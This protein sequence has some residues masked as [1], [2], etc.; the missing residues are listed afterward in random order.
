MPYY[1]YNFSGILDSY[2]GYYLFM[3][4]GILA[5]LIASIAVKSTFRRYSSVANSRGMTGADA[6]LAVLRAYG[7]TDVTV[8]RVSGNL[9][10]NYDPR[11]KVIHLSESVY[12]SRS[13]AAVGVAAHEAGHAAQ[14]AAG[15]APVKLRMA[16]IPVCNIGAQLALPLLIL[17]SVFNFFGLMV[18]GLALF[19]LS[20]FFQ[21]VTLPVEFNASRRALAV[22]REHDLL[23]GEEY[24]GAKKTLTAAAMTYVAALFQSVLSLLWFLFR[25]AGRRR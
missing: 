1:T 7:V 5:V 12:D 21:L 10:D 23:V 9:T 2:L 13:V 6:A 17:G 11:R 19:A 8:E 14:Y 22:I 3:I 18:A 15:Y 16:M 24:T 25:V 4:P 20:V